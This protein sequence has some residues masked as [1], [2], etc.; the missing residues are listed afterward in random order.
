MRYLLTTLLCLTIAANCLAQVPGVKRV[1]LIGVDGMS[2]NGVQNAPTPNM[3]YLVKKGSSSFTAQAVMPSSSSTNWAS[4]VMGAGP[5]LHGVTSNAWQPNKQ[6][7]KLECTGKNGRGKDSKMWPTFYGELRQQK[8]NAKIFCFHDWLAYGRLVEKGVC[9]RNCGP[10]LI[11]LIRGKG[12]DQAVRRGIRQ[13]KKKDFD[14]LFIHLDH[15]DH[16]GHKIGHGTPEYYDAVAYADVLIGKVIEAVRAA[17]LEDETII[18]ITADHGGIG[19][20]HGGNTP[21]E[22]TIPWIVKGPGIKANHTVSTPVVT[23]D[24]ALT[25]CKLFGLTPPDC[26]IGKPILDA[27]VSQ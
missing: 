17:G 27:L 24:T 15:V 8:P 22:M 16:V 4:M 23:Y 18:M 20:G 6:I 25:L 7:I 1:I 13:I 21:E 11:P 2:P 19:K 10:S 14:F 26:W 9:N 3:D 12:N 5:D